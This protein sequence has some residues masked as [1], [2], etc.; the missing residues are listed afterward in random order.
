MDPSAGRELH[1]KAGGLLVAG[2]GFLLSRGTLLVVADT[3]GSTVAFLTTGF[4]PL[5]LG[6][7]LA[8]FGVSLAVSTFEPWYVNVVALWTLIGTAGMGLVTALSLVNPMLAEDTMIATVQSSTLVANT[9]IGGAV[10]GSLIGVRSARNRR[11]RR[12][13]ARQSDQVVVLDRILRDE[14]LNAVTAI[15]ARAEILR[16]SG[17]DAESIEVIDRATDRIRAAVEDVGFLVKTHDDPVGQEPT[18]LAPVLR[19]GLAAVDDQYP[20]ATVDAAVDVDDDLS[21]RANDRLGTVFG[22]LC[23]TAVERHPDRAP[24][25]RVSVAATDT[26]ATVTVTDDGD[27]LSEKQATV[28]T[29]DTISEY[30]DPAISFGYPI[31][32]FL[33]DQYG[34]A[35]TAERDGEETRVTVSLPRVHESAT[36]SQRHGVEPVALRDVTVAALLAG[37]AMGTILQVFADTIPV[38]GS[39]YG[40]ASVPVG[41]ITHLFHSV[42][43]GVFFAAT[44]RRPFLR[45]RVDS[46]GATVAVAVGFGLLL[47]VGVAGLVMPVWLNAV[48]VSAPLPR[49][50]PAGVVGHV[51]WGLVL[52]SVYWL[53][54][55]R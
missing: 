8:A 12:E 10:G 1:L 5:A 40:V 38:I 32:S 46:F 34:G 41:W 29:A 53:L 6:L 26:A 23:A 4:A 18:A 15:H 51:V 21:V 2:V 22:Q 42:V 7:A 24:H 47:A 30:D 37:V 14:V 27:P 49:I 36:P 28:L 17:T 25:I 16:S 44:L 45:A 11:Q 39:L 52:G 55:R 33:V 35:V 43:F 13:L 54:S 9:L 19:E 20:D 48:G 31:V 50:F 3:G